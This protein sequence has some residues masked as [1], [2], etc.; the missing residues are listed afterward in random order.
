MSPLTENTT[1][2]E[3]ITFLVEA[4]TTCVDDETATELTSQIQLLCS[5][6]DFLEDCYSYDISDL[7]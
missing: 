1:A 2:Q 4:A 5:Q 7:D 3:F 6:I